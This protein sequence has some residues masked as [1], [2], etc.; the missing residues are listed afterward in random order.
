[1]DE[2]K[3]RGVKLSSAKELGKKGKVFIGMSRC[4]LY[5]SMGDP[6]KENVDIG[7]WGVHV[8]HV[9]NGMNVY[10]ENDTVTSLQLR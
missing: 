2:I 10:S 1:L 4:D 6:I 8:Q 3:R 9:Y 7:K 5:I